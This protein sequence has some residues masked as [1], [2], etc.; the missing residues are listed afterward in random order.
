[1]D[2]RDSSSSFSALP[3]NTLLLLSEEDGDKDLDMAM[4]IIHE[5][6]LS[7]FETSAASNGSTPDELSL[8]NALYQHSADEDS[9]SIL[10]PPDTLDTLRDPLHYQEQRQRSTSTTLTHKK[11]CTYQNRREEIQVL[12]DEVLALESRVRE[13]KQIKARRRQEAE[14]NQREKRESVAMVADEN[15]ELKA[16]ILAQKRELSNLIACIHAN[17]LLTQPAVKSE[18]DPKTP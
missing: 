17:R 2:P 4:S 15:I 14:R 1:M 10:E 11:K 7:E 16:A 3:F 6:D 13:L 18:Q 9:S 12:R 5:L 8:L